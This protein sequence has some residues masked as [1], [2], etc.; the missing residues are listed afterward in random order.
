MPSVVGRDS[1]G[2]FPLKGKLLNIREATLNQRK[3]NQEINALKKIGLQE[4]K[5]IQ[6]LVSFDMLELL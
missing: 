4:G 5:Y 3:N 6:I 1:Y 2:V